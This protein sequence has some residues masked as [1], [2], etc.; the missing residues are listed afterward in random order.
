[1]TF[2]KNDV[3]LEETVCT[4]IVKNTFITLQSADAS[5]TRRVSVPAS[6]R[7]CLGTKD[8]SFHNNF[9]E[10][11]H[12]RADSE[13][14]TDVCTECSDE[15]SGYRTPLL[16]D[17]EDSLYARSLPA[18]PVRRPFIAP[19]LAGDVEPPPPPFMPA[20]LSTKPMTARQ[21]AR[22]SSAAP[23]FKPLASKEDAMSHQYDHHFA[24]IVKAAVKTMRDSQ[25]TSNVDVSDSL[26]DCAI[27]IQKRGDAVNTEQVLELAYHA[28]L[29][30]ASKSKFI[31]VMGFTSQKP[32][33]AC[34][35]GF[36]ATLGAM[37]SATTACWH[38]FKKGF[39]RHGD[40]CRKQHPSC[41]MPIRILVETSQLHA[42]IPS[43]CDFKLKVADFVHQVVS[44]VETS[45]SCA[46]V[47][48]TKKES[49]KCWTIEL[50]PKAD[51]RV[52]DE[53]LLSQ[54]KSIMHTL[55]NNEQGVYM[56]GYAANPF[57]SCSTGCV[58]VLG[59]MV[60]ET[61]ACWDFYSKG[62]C[63]KG[64]DCK[65]EHPNC[66]MPINIMIKSRLQSR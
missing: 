2:Y 37:E 3:T 20:V 7:L 29:D 56:L 64:C 40:D 31:F 14:S 58:V 62:L 53:Y 24:R 32:S 4:P 57:V 48:A 42:P 22:L 59:D 17:D 63:R 54:V 18:S 21:S 61:R 38:I 15:E 6:A 50:T 25:L 1:M 5:A 34:P 46:R 13:V 44:A 35:M 36:E 19:P 55:S 11:G 60:A 33:N 39:C 16:S 66:S 23:A 47:E 65:W 43:I 27:V 12:P 41:T 52:N 28:L 9:F 49:S 30:A 51:G 8:C 45:A 26:R 10:I